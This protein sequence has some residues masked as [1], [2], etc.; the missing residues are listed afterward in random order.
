MAS[1]LRFD[2]PEVKG[3]TAESGSADPRV[4][5]VTEA[6]GHFH[7]DAHS[8]RIVLPGPR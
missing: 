1:I 3:L 4:A 5:P 7:G 6:A 2:P 8:L